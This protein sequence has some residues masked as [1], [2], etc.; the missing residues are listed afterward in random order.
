MKDFQ[1]KVVSAAV[2][3]ATL[4]ES[5]PEGANIDPIAGMPAYAKAKAGDPEYINIRYENLSDLECEELTKGLPGLEWQDPTSDTF[6][7]RQ[8]WLGGMSY[9]IPPPPVARKVEHKEKGRGK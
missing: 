2:N 5:L 7:V 6:Q 3:L 8:E 4:A 9:Y 1:F